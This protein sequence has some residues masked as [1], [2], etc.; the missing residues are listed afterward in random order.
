[1]LAE[2]SQENVDLSESNEQFID[3]ISCLNTQIEQLNF[4]LQNKRNLLQT[5]N[6]TILQLKEK[7]DESESVRISLSN[8]IQNYTE[9]ISNL[10]SENEKLNKQIRMI[11][12]EYKKLEKSLEENISY[13][14]EA[15]TELKRRDR[16]IDYLRKQA[17]EEAADYR[18]QLTQLSTQTEQ[19]RKGRGSGA[20]KGEDSLARRRRDG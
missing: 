9:R 3:Q 5:S 12:S 18:F 10:E 1:M 19:L 4:E 17:E 2:K 11:A 7:L 13:C 14:Q 16:A 6:E 15:Q 8:N 20:V